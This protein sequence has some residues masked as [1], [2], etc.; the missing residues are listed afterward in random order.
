M[1]ALLIG[2]RRL[3]PLPFLLT[4][5]ACGPGT[6]ST[7]SSSGNSSGGNVAACED[8]AGAIT[9]CN[10]QHDGSHAGATVTFPDPL[11][12]TYAPFVLTR[13]GTTVTKAFFVA[14][15]TGGPNRGAM[16]TFSGTQ[17]QVDAITLTAGT[18]INLTATV[19]EVDNETRLVMEGTPSVASQAGAIP[20]PTVTT[21]ATLSADSTAEPYEGVLV[22]VENVKATRFSSGAIQEYGAFL[23]EGGVQVDDQLFGYE[24]GVDETFSQITGFVRYF[25]GAWM[26]L[27]RDAADVVSS[28]NPRAPRLTHINE[29]QDPANLSTL[30]HCGPTAECDPLRFERLVVVSNPRQADD[31]ANG[32]STLF[33]V[34][35]QD[36]TLL[37]A[38][39]EPLPYS[40]VKL[41]FPRR[42]NLPESTYELPVYGDRDLPNNRDFPDQWPKPGDII[43]VEGSV[44]EFFDNTQISNV[45]KL[46]KVGTV[47]EN[48]EMVTIPVAKKFSGD[49]LAA[50]G[51]GQLEVD[52]CREGVAPGSDVEK[53]E[54]ILVELQNV[55]TTMACV[56]TPTQDTAAPECILRDF[57]YIQV[58]GGVEVGTGQGFYFTEFGACPSGAIC[59][60]DGANG[61]QTMDPNLDSR[62][63]DKV[64]TS[65]TGVLDYSFSVFRVSPRGDADVVAAP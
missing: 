34:H 39:K 7:S 26:I 46:V 17:E 42:E 5:L 62:E 30:P 14:E 20:Q 54:G 2:A 48:P 40:G 21:V 25:A 9:L 13:N 55:T 47:T 38:N 57:G 28:G 1:K 44:T 43:D 32:K 36:P 51:A 60:C 61:T 27:P 49:A 37:D 29:I 52:G 58:T 53:W 50:I 12:V 56:P 3:A 8:V 41:V 10:V 19:E 23:L 35:V 45:V 11:V 63:A 18:E 65:I 64:Y 33:S 22:R 16:V 15:G 4:G 24:N 59:T 6:G 31:D